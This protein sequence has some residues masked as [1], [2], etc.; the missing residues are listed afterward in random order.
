MSVICTLNYY[1]TVIAMQMTHVYDRLGAKTALRPH[2]YY[3]E[4]CVH[5]YYFT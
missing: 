4:L 1:R 3:I 2:H 5:L